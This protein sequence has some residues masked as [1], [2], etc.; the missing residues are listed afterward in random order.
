MVLSFNFV[1]LIIWFLQGTKAEVGGNKPVIYPV[2]EKFLLFTRL[3]KHVFDDLAILSLT[4]AYQKFLVWC[5]TDSEC[6][7]LV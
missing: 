7:A 4:K 1:C 3:H 5:T 2:F 6:D